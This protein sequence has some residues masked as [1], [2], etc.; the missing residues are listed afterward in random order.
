VSKLRAKI[1]CSKGKCN[2]ALQ[3]VR[4]SSPVRFNPRQF[5]VPPIPKPSSGE[6]RSSLSTSV[7]CCAHKRRFRER[8]N[9]VTGNATRIAGS[10][11]K[12]QPRQA[13]QMRKGS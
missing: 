11:K 3:W 8:R 2:A 9:A 10:D 7:N 6:R 5:D 13:P 1:F 12:T 4:C